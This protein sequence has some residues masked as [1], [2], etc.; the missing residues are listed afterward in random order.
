MTAT[1]W[2]Q[3]LAAAGAA[4]ATFAAAACGDIASPARTDVYEWRAE[5]SAVPGPGLDTLAFHW[6]LD[7]LPVRIWVEDAEDLPAHVARAIEVWEDVF[8]YGEFRGT[9]VS[10]SAAADV[11]VRAGPPESEPPKTVRHSA[12]APECSGATDLDVDD[13]N[14]QLTLPIRVFLDPVPV[15]GVER[16]LALTSIHELGHALGMFAHSDAASDIMFGQPD[17]ELPSDRDRRTAEAAYHTPPT[18]QVVGRDVP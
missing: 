11:I 14:T 10:D 17:V 18:L 12:T 5:R 8:L 1:I 16:C 9:L 15:P 7:H 13:G 6:G 3:R 2:T 4:G